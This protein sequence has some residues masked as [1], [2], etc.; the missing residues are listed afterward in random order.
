[1]VRVNTKILGLYLLYKDIL[2]HKKIISK[3]NYTKKILNILKKY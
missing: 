3:S 1:M 2:Y